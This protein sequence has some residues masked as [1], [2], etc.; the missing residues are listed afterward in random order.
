MKRKGAELVRHITWKLKASGGV[1]QRVM[2]PKSRGKCWGNS[3]VHLVLGRGLGILSKTSSGVD[4]EYN[5][6]KRAGPA[7]RRQK[8]QRKPT[9]GLSPLRVR[10]KGKARLGYLWGGTLRGGAAEAFLG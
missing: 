7:V 5:R 1:G 9:P 2:Q 8:E 4:S 6:E 10:K 3:K